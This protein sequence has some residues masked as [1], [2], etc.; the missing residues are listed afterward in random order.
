ME[1]LEITLPSKTAIFLVIIVAG[2]AGPPVAHAY[3]DPGTGGMVYQILVLVGAAATGALAVFRNKIKA[4][5]GSK[6][7]GDD[8]AGPQGQ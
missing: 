1:F 4:M 3:V 6:A 2:L 7:K 5:F 8:G